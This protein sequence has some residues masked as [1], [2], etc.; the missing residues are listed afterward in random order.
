[1]RK[2]LKTG[3]LG[4][5]LSALTIAM[6]SP[7]GAAHADL[8]PQAGD[9]VGVG[10]DTVQY[11]LDFGADGDFSGDTGYNATGAI[12][13]LVS[14]D[15]TPDANAR[16][17]YLNG[18]TNTGLKPL[19]PTVVLRAG[20]HPVQRPNGSG[21]GIAALIADTGTTETIN[22]VRSSRLPKASEQT[23]AVNAGW[24]YL[25]VV[26]LGTEPL[27]MAEA[28]STNAPSGLSLQELIKIYNGTWTTWSQ[29]PGATGTDAIIPLIPQNGSG[30]RSSFLAD[31]QAANGGTAI[32]LG[33]NVQTVEENDPTSITGA[34]NPLD[35]IAPF[36]GSRLALYNK[37]Y[38]HDSSAVFPGGAAL[39]PGIK[40]ASGT[41]ADTN[42]V[43]ND[44]RGLY[45]LYRDSDRT[46]AAAFQPGGTKNLVNTLFSGS[47]PYFKS[48]AG[49]A[50]VAA[51]GAT[52]AYSDLGNVSSG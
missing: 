32:T 50:L 52:A 15:A 8:A 44:V 13:R 38:F 24:G 2:T 47:N 51:A 29:V 26:Q 3:L 22:Y 33:G 21:A 20:A 28:N 46:A 1:M 12:N 48:G 17:G 34:S 36:S 18:S 7:M 37:G 41:P 35:A 4:A 6:L 27:Q 40:L 9:A 19:N 42:P 30:T 39:S 14:F 23:A 49:Q 31:L 5:T 11:I 10:S 25:H 16:A 45:V 43:Y